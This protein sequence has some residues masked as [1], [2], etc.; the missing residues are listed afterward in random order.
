MKRA[1]KM[2]RGLEDFS[3]LF[4]SSKSEKNEPPAGSKQKAVCEVKSAATPARV[5][6]IAGD[7]KVAERAFITA[8]LALELANQG[9]RVVVVDADFSLPRLCMLMGV[10]SPN[11]LLH[12]ISGNGE[13][14]ITA[15]GVDGVKL[16][17][18]DADITDLRFL[19]ESERSSLMRYFR[20]AEEAAEIILVTV[21]PGF[22]H[23]MRTIVK[24]SSEIVV[25]TPQPL[26]EMIDA[27]AVIKTIF[28]ANKSARV[29]ILSSRIVASDQA[30]AVFEKMQRIVKKFL[31]KPLY[32][33]GYISE[34]REI[35]LSMAR[36]EPLLKTSP[37][38]QAVKC[39][40]E[41]SHSI[42]KVDGNGNGEHPV[43]RR[44]F[45]FT[46]RLFNK[47]TV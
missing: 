46:E 21:S 14:D 16:I 25:I 31:D 24:A 19:K 44:N 42:L 11:S 27:Y 1:K 35:S 13:E 32:N 36:R 41:I 22:I 20:S 37:S 6:C 10:P 5:I 4:L 23:H 3:H 33:Y 9:K 7:K 29:G 17:T 8:N 38:S 28:Q 45:S 2:G 34:D 40:A 15:E 47:S 43:D 18:L 39:I 26:A 30:D 12:Y